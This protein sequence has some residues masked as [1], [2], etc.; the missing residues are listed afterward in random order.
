M[1]ST[2]FEIFF[3]QRNDLKN[4]R[5]PTFFPF[6]FEFNTFGLRGACLTIISRPLNFISGL[7]AHCFGINFCAYLYRI[8]KTVKK[9]QNSWLMC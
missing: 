6:I 1:H 2:H 7:A 5:T 3:Y 8:V 9:G 4:A